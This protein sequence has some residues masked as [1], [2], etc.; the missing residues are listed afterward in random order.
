MEK[1]SES[2]RKL[3]KKRGNTLFLIK[4]IGKFVKTFPFGPDVYLT[5]RV[6]WGIPG[7]GKAS[8]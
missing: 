8:S 1:I 7:S 3:V 5:G 4:N 2:R 6:I